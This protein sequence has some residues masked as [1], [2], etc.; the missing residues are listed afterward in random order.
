MVK[1]REQRPVSVQRQRLQGSI[2]LSGFSSA[3]QSQA[4]QLLHPQAAPCSLLLQGDSPSRSLLHRPSLPPRSEGHL[5]SHTP[6]VSLPVAYAPILASI[7]RQQ[8]GKASTFPCIPQEEN[9]TEE[10][11]PHQNSS[12][13][14]IT[15]YMAFEVGSSPKSIARSSCSQML[16]Q[17]GCRHGSTPHQAGLYIPL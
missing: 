15:A 13:T 3:A 8:L 7:Q 11:Y 14:V 1:G 12:R 9:Y 5:C 10:I 4:R 16:T 2:L 17:K 6:W